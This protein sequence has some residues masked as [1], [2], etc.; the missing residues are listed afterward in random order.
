MLSHYAAVPIYTPFCVTRLP[1]GAQKSHTTKR[2]AKMG[3]LIII[4]GRRHGT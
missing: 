4:V 1:L 3:A 2:L